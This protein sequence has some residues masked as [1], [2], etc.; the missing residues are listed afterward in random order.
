MP[1]IVVSVVLGAAGALYGYY[2]RD[3]PGS[4]ALILGMAVGALT[5]AGWRTWERIR[6]L[7]RPR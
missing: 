1:R 2:G 4:L 5:W 7:H 6:D 3:Y